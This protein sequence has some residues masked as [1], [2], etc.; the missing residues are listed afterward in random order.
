[1]KAKTILLVEDEEQ[2]RVLLERVLV[3]NDY[4]VLSA[5]N[6][7]EALAL[8]QG[9]INDI[10]LVISDLVMPELGGVGL[11]RELRLIRSDIPFLYMTG[12]SEEDVQQEG[13]LEGAHL[14]Q[15][16]FTPVQ[17]MQRI[18]DL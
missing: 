3:K 9:K 11:L 1:M 2:V 18:A 15:K 6:G 4:K 17:L 12:Y 5:T 16:P 14:I 10:D 8:A 13:P 7:R